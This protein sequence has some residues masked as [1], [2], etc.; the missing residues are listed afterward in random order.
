MGFLSGEEVVR[1]GRGGRAGFFEAVDGRVCAVG[2]V[3]CF[4]LFFLLRQGF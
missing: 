3:D 1:V 4:G 2:D